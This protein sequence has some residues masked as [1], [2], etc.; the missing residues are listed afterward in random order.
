M[1]EPF[2]QFSNLKK[3]PEII[4]GISNR[5]YGEMGFGRIP[6]EQVVKNRQNFCQRLKIDLPDLIV[7]GLVHRSRIVV[8]GRKEKGAG[9]LKVSTA[10]A[11]ADGLITAQRKLFLMV[12][13][14]DCL[15]VLFYDPF[16][17]VVG[18]I[19]AGWR[20][21][22]AGIV[23]QSLEKFKN[24]GTKPENLIVGIGPSICQKHFVVQ[25]D[26]LDKFKQYNKKAVFIRNHDGYVDLKKTVL[27][28]LKN[29]GVLAQNIE[30]AQDCPV[31]HN[32][33]YSSFRK[34]GRKAPAQAA[35]I[36]MG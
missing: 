30:I 14:A 25:K 36:G 26:V 21:I 8:V 13:V 12:T 24:C 15:P 33:L 9:S 19:H 17:A 32:S 31:C 16:L 10:I 28:D 35:I 29:A 4:H 11:Q 34:E 6:D 22:L 1:R 3:F 7:A 23:P 2:F 18:I 5:N 20:G 27:D